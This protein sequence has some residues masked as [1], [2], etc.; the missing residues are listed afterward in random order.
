[1]SARQFQSPDL[2]KRIRDVLE[3]T[4]MDARCLELELNESVLMQEGDQTP[5]VLAA[6]SELGIGFALD[7]FGTGYSSLSYFKRCPV[8]RVKIARSFVGDIATREGDA[9][10]ARAVIAMARGLGIAVV[11]QGIETVEQLAILR[12]YG[13]DEGQGYLLGRPVMASEVP[14]VMRRHQWSA[15]RRPAA[16]V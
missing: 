10:V 13:C 5:S 3:Q 8:A 6:L 9:A 14:E 15:A 1:M 16:V 11:A 2:E 12:R 7:N 4:G